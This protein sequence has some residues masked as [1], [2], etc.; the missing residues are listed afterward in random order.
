MMM[1][2]AFEGER[3]SLYFDVFFLWD[4]IDRDALS[5]NNMS[6]MVRE[7]RSLYIYM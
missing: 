2:F 4:R 3:D 5:A 1:L 7:E 6:N